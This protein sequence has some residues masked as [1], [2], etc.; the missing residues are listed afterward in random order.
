MQTQAEISILDHRLKSM[1]TQLESLKINIKDIDSKT[2]QLINALVGN[3]LSDSKG[4]AAEF[5][6]MKKKVYQHEENFKKAKWF[7][8]GIG[9]LGGIIFALIQFIIKLFFS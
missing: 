1:E 4:L 8:L 2:N 5:N 9:T 3:P 7:A 6:S